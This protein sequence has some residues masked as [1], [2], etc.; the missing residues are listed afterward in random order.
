MSYLAQ[1]AVVDP[2]TRIRVAG[3]QLSGLAVPALLAAVALALAAVWWQRGT[4]LPLTWAWPSAS[5]LWLLPGLPVVGLFA[6]RVLAGGPHQSLASDGLA[7]AAARWAAVWVGV[8]AIWSVVTVAGLYGGLQARGVPDNLVAVVAHSDD[9]VA[10]LAVLWVALLVALLG[11]RLG[12]WRES[13]ALLALVVVALLAGL[14]EAAARHSH[15]DGA[16]AAPLLVAGVQ[17]VSVVLW[18][19]ALVA[20]THLQ[21][22]A[23]QLRHHLV[24]VGFL[25]SGAAAALGATAVVAGLLLP[26]GA[27]RTPV[28]LAAAQL[29]GLGLVVAVGHRLR[30]RSVTGAATGPRRALVLAVAGELVLLAAVVGL[31]FV[32]PV[33]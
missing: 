16:L 28:V 32:L 10:R 24:R 17:R 3:Q 12:G 20:L 4:A 11:R 31:G 5:A 15:D 21:P 6:L 26:V 9:A 22:P 8:T 19:G 14:P 13:A 33:G 25:L 27:G 30:V 2:R 7:R 18:L 29:L 23:Y 1:R